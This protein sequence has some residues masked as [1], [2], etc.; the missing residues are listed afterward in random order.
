MS[1]I[2]G[3]IF[4]FIYFGLIFSVVPLAILVLVMHFLM[5][6]AVLDRYWK[7]PHFRPR[8]LERFSG[9]SRY[10]PYRTILFMSIVLFPGIGIK[11]GIIEPYR[12]MPR[13]YRIV[14]IVWCVWSIVVLAGFSLSFVG[15]LVY[16]HIIGELWD[17]DMY[18][19][20]AVTLGGVTF[21]AIQR[22]RGNRRNATARGRAKKKAHH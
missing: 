9:W 14:S 2:T 19:A 1:L 15:Y 6:E 16:S 11:R 3:E 18:V 17:W 8:E 10:A 22:R 20:L 21:L 5:P 7:E 13:W 12:L 4:A